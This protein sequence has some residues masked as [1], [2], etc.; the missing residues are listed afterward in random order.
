MNRHHVRQNYFEFFG[1]A[2]N[3]DI[4]LNALATSYRKIQAEAH[5]DKFVTASTS[6]KMQS[7][8][9]ATFA[10]DAYQTLKQP[11]L[12]AAYLLS[13]QGITAISETNTA[14]PT[15]F[16]MQQMEW[17]E[18]LEDAIQASNVQAIE[19]LAR[20]LKTQENDL[21]TEFKTHFDEKKDFKSATDI[22]RKL[23]FID[24]VSADTKQ[25]L[26]LLD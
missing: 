2:V 8:Q 11:A 5:P 10:N 25:A 1:L 22:A 4:S 18:L 9:T 7:M 14:M 15:D 26:A 3:F 13:L 19:S 6:E 20:E 23:I 12:R 24:K 17:R 16:L 21:Q